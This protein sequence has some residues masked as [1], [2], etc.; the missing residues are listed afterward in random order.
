M[1]QVKN[2]GGKNRLCSFQNSINKLLEVLNSYHGGLQ[3]ISVLWTH[4]Q[5]YHS[6]INSTQP[7]MI[8]ENS[9]VLFVF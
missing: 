7:C 6:F 1:S 3:Q 9:D 2:L 5:S 4:D 8:A